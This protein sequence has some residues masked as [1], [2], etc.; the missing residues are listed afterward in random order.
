MSILRFMSIISKLLAY[1]LG[2]LVIYWLFLKV[3]GHSPASDQ[4][5][6]AYLGAL[7]TGIMAIVGVLI[8]MSGDV[9][10]LRGEFRQFMKHVDT[11]LAHINTKLDR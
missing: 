8:K 10:E 9:R 3:T 11:E 6:L 2:L 4:V 5:I 1:C 7:T